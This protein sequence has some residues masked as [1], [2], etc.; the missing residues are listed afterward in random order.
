MAPRSEDNLADHQ[1]NYHEGG[2][3]GD[4]IK[5]AQPPG[6][7][8]FPAATTTRAISQDDDENGEDP[9]NTVDYM[10]HPDIEI[11][12]NVGI[13]SPSEHKRID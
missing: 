1:Q 5:I 8:T 10:S 4:G 11:D 3:V 13:S 6:V 9:S 12:D 7:S 2:N